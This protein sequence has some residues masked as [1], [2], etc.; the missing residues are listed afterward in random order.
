MIIINTNLFILFVYKVFKL[1]NMQKFMRPFASFSIKS[2]NYTCGF[3]EICLSDK[4]IK[5]GVMNLRMGVTEIECLYIKISK[6]KNIFT[7]IS[8]FHFKGTS[9]LSNWH[10]AMVCNEYSLIIC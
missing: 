3:F 4:I 8:I 9:T 1:T 7:Q 2:S 6:V 10:I 5:E